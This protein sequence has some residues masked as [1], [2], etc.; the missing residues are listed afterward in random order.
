MQWFDKTQRL[1]QN[2]VLA[3]PWIRRYILVGYIGK[4]ALYLSI[5]IL[6]VRASI[7]SNHQASGTYLTLTFVTHQP[8]GRGFVSLLAVALGG[9]VLRRLLQA[10]QVLESS[11]FWSVKSI[12]QRLGYLMS[13]FTYAGVI[14][15]AFKIV[16]QIGEYDD[17]IQD[18]ANEIFEQPIGEWL[19]L[20]GGII[21]TMIGGFYIYGAYTGSY[22][23]ELRSV[24]IN[25]RLEKWTIYIGKLGVLSRGIAFILIGIFLIQAAIYGTADL[26]GGLQNAFR[27]IAT[28]PLGWLWLRLMGMG[29][30]GY[31]L[32]MFVAAKYRRYAIR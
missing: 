20:L 12:V 30:M 1:L 22:I 17:T 27:E 6:A 9:Y 26:A 14:Y 11:N 15:S 18:L 3:N 7:M 32:Y 31:G 4:G 13:A 8:W 21:V 16:L 28:Q 10:V 25:Y 19:I 23:S 24:D 5:G 2:K 29:L